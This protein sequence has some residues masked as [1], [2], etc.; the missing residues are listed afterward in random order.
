MRG[1]FLQLVRRLDL[2]LFILCDTWTQTLS[3]PFTC[4][5][6]KRK[7]VSFPFVLIRSWELKPEYYARI[8]VQ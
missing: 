5:N 2:L 8:V 6:G 7:D 4:G 1:R 3:T